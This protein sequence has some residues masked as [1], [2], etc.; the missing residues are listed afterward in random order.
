MIDDKLLYEFDEHATDSRYTASENLYPDLDMGKLSKYI[1]NNNLS[2]KDL[3]E[4]KIEEILNKEDL[5][6]LDELSPDGTFTTGEDI[7]IHFNIGKLREYVKKNNISLD[8][9]TEEEKYKILNT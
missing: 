9:L 6:K 5:Y 2:W 8:D 1:K 3:T 4:E 7:P